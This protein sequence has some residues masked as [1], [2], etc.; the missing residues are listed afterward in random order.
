MDKIKVA[1]LSFEKGVKAYLSKDFQVAEKYFLEA[2]ENA[3]QSIPVLE[4]LSKTETNNTTTKKLKLKKM[5][6]Q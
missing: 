1:K 3:P 2:L 5:F 6:L 4:N